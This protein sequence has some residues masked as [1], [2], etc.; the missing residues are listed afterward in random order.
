MQELLHAL[1]H[2]VIDSL[3]TIPFLIIAFMIL[4]IIESK[5]EEKSSSVI[6]R[7]GKTGPLAGALLGL[8]PQC[9]FSVLGSNFYA[10]RI[11]TLGTLVAIYLSTSDEAL[12]VMLATPSRILDVLMIMGLKFGIGVFAGYLIDLILRKKAVDT[13]CH[14]YHH[15]EDSC[16]DEVEIKVY[17]SA[18]YEQVWQE[19]FDCGHEYG[20]R[21]KEFLEKGLKDILNFVMLVIRKKD[22]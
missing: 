5:I 4:E 22:N 7:A 20:I 6:E 8:V 12:I 18:H 16:E 3:T 19:W 17:E 15:H 10:K 13:E 1:K 14:H 21:D 2:A 9:G 11:I